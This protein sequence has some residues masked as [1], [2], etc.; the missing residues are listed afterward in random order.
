MNITIALS[1]NGLISISHSPLTANQVT[2]TSVDTHNQEES[3][4]AEPKAISQEPAEP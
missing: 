2:I 4:I 1:N 3:A